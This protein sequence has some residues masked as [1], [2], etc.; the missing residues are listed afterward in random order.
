MHTTPAA[1][2]VMLKPSSATVSQQCNAQS[3]N[4]DSCRGDKKNKGQSNNVK[5][6]AKRNATQPNIEL[7]IVAL[8]EA[9]YIKPKDVFKH[10]QG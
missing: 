6:Q 10:G 8:R 7:E 2:S 3:G 1:I 4:N 5:L 9:R